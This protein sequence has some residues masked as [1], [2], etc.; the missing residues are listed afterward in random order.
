MIISKLKSDGCTA[1][2]EKQI[3]RKYTPISQIRISN[4]ESK[5]ST[6]LPLS[7]RH[8]NFRGRIHFRFSLCVNYS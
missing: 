3:V 7:I 4:L 8:F 1:R 6:L 5:I 2:L